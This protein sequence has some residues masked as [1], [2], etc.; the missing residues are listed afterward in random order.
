VVDPAGG[1]GIGCG[2]EDGGVGAQGDQFDAGVVGQPDLNGLLGVAEAG[3]AH[4][5]GAAGFASG[6]AGFVEVDEVSGGVG[7]SGGADGSV[8]DQVEA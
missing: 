1:A 6:D 8:D 3:E 4:G 2:F 7:V 5:A